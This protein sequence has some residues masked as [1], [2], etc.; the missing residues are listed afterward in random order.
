MVRYHYEY[1]TAIYKLYR[2]M[3]RY[4]R[5]MERTIGRAARLMMHRGSIIKYPEEN[6]RNSLR[7]S[8]KGQA[9]EYF[10]SYQGNPKRFEKATR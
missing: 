2:H 7:Y 10:F 6:V 4:E 3:H 5:K 8:L 1:T 9:L